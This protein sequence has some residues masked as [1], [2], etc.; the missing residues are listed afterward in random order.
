MT[1]SLRAARRIALLL[2]LLLLAPQTL[3]AQE[4]EPPAS[5][6]REGETPW[7]Y[8]N[9]D[10]PRD[11]EWQFGELANGLRYGVRENG[12]PPG[13]VSI[14]VRI[15]AGSLYE[16]DSELGYAHLLEHLLFRESKYL[17]VAEAIPTW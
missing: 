9:S 11:E 2:P 7:I 6:Q 1:D 14:R 15:D 10:V 17:G 8:E 3:P 5:L 12:V 4:V 16:S 13:Q